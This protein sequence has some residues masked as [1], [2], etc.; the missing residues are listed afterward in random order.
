MPLDKKNNTLQNVKASASRAQPGV[1]I[2]HRV[3][4]L[5]CRVLAQV[6]LVE[7]AHVCLGFVSRF[8]NRY[9]EDRASESGGWRKKKTR[10]ACVLAFNG[11]Q[12]AM[13]SSAVL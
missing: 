1:R 13:P 2:G 6:L 8:A 11:E 3:G 10:H 9:H 7:I 5:E 4:A 12:I